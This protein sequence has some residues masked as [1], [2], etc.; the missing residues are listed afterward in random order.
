MKLTF[1]LVLPVKKK[2]LGIEDI[3]RNVEFKKCHDS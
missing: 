2:I 1:E 3:S